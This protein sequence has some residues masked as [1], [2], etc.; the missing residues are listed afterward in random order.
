M[1]VVVA[2]VAVNGAAGGE[3]ALVVLA[4][5][6]RPAAGRATG[7][8]SSTSRKSTCFLKLS[9]L[10]TCTVNWSPS[11]MTRRVRRPTRLLRAASNT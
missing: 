2:A 5:A 8:R 11:R 6:G 9:T 4:V 3:L 10:A 1:H 7:L